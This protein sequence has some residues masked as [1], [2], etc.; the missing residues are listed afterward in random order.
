MIELLDMIFYIKFNAHYF[1]ASIEISF[2][3]FGF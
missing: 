1:Y 2:A 3:E